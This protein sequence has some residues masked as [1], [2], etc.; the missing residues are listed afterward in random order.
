M[1]TETY[2]SPE[3]GGDLEQ[4]KDYL[5]DHIKWDATTANVVAECP[6]R[7]EYQVKMRLVSKEEG[8]PLRAGRAIHAAMAVYYTTKDQ[9]AAMLALKESW[10]EDSQAWTVTPKYAHLTLGHLA[11]VM[12]R[13]FPWAAKSDAFTPLVV[14]RDEM[15]LEKVLYGNWLITDDERV[16]LGESKFMMRFLVSNNPFIYSGRPDLPVAMGDRLFVFDHKSTNAYLSSWYFDQHRHSNQLRGYGAMLNEVLKKVVSGSLINGVYIGEK[17]ASS[18]YGGSRFA[19]FGPMLYQPGHLYEAIQNQYHWA[20]TYAFH[21]QNDYFPQHTSKCCSG[22]QFT[23]LCSTSAVLR[24]AAAKN[25]F[26]P[27]KVDF[28]DL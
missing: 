9:D 8:L 3:F 21:E 28:F 6:R 23:G 19:R 18:E 20:A 15:D 22:C 24:K 12:E 17:A 16:V 7:A 1:K 2:V 13:Y 27:N 10:G 14:H 5:K 11:V 26:V 25:D 4:L